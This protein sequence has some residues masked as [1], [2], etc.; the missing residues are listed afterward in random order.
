MAKV[1]STYF[2]MTLTLVVVTLIA[3]TALG[4]VYELTKEPIAAAK[5]AK[6]K[7]AIDAVV[8]AYDND[9]IADQYKIGIASLKDSLEVYPAK[10]A[11]EKQGIAIKTVSPKGYGGNVWIMVGFLPDGSIHNISVLE[12]KETPGLGT[13][14]NQPKFIDQFIGKNPSQFNLKVKKDGG[15]VD[16]LTGATISTRAFGSAVQTAYDAINEGGENE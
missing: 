8:T 7:K 4:F 11:G 14:M 2:N 15:D 6:Q 10:L 16:A 5:L 3:S 1:E 9:P 12:H 13:K